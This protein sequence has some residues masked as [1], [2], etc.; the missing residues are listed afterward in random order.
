VHVEE[1]IKKG[2]QSLGSNW[3]WNDLHTLKF[4]KGTTHGSLK[5]F[6]ILQIVLH[7]EGEKASFTCE[8]F[9]T[10]LALRSRVFIKFPWSKIPTLLSLVSFFI[11]L[12]AKCVA[13][14]SSTKLLCG[15]LSHQL[16][17]STIV[18]S[19]L[20]DRSGDAQ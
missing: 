10:S 5:I 2:S 11:G 18:R 13:F 9:K 8:D 12:L 17:Q 6:A 15:F 16:F 1:H 7:V 14:M 20:W 19:V 4:Q 3:I